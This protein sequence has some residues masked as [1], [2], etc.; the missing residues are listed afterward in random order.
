MRSRKK[1]GPLPMTGLAR[2]DHP[3]EYTEYRGGIL[4]EGGKRQCYQHQLRFLD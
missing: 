3:N 2:L 4:I 1:I